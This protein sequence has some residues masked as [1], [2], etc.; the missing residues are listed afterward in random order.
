MKKS[1]ILLDRNVIELVCKDKRFSDSFLSLI[2]IKDPVFGMPPMLFLE[3]L[4]FNFNSLPII[5]ISLAESTK[6]FS[7]LEKEK[8]NGNKNFFEII[9]PLYENKISEIYKLLLD[10]SELLV[11]NLKT[12]Y[13]KRERDYTSRI[14]KAILKC[15]DVLLNEKQLYENVLE[16]LTIGLLCTA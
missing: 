10:N 8:N 13:K 7:Q 1:D 11:S 12:L 15:C 14:G 4:G 9:N 16:I 5:N 2:K 6:Y 3:T